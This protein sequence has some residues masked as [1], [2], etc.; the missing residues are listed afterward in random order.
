MFFYILLGCALFAALSYAVTQS[1]RFIGGTGGAI[2]EAEKT[3][4]ITSDIKQYLEGLK[5]QVAQLTTGNS[6]SEGTLD[7]RNDIYKLQ[8]GTDNTGNTN[9]NC[10]ASSCRIFTPY[11]TSGITPMVFNDAAN[12]TD[13][14]S[15]T[16]PKNGHGQVRQIILN[17][18]GST[19]PELVFIIHGVSADFCNSYNKQ[20]NI[21]TNYNSSTT[22]TSIGENSTSSVPA[23]F[24]GSFN[25]SNSFGTGA[26]I[27]SGKKTFC[28]PAYTDS[29]T[30]RLA[31][32]QTLK[33]R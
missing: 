16:L 8:D 23:A 3:S 27:F 22:L 20:E 7:F 17:G 19:A 31:I 6:I 11:N 13:Q 28:A 12:K 2:G 4:L 10:T 21:T 1:I 24:S 18:V 32:W 30:S 5:I 14:T 25:T 26:T 29:A 15:S 9:S 33:I